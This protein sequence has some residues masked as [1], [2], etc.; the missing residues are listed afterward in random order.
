VTFISRQLLK[1]AVCKKNPAKKSM[2]V[3]ESFYIFAIV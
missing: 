1:F 2:T 3:R